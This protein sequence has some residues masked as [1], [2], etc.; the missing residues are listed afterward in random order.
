MSFRIRSSEFPPKIT[1][2]LVKSNFFKCLDLVLQFAPERTIGTFAPSSI[3]LYRPK[4]EPLSVESPGEGSW[5][6]PGVQRTAQQIC[7]A[8]TFWISS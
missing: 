7:L 8:T 4:T 6:T 5:Q 2:E 1:K 3:C